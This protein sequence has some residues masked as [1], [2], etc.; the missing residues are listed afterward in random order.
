MGAS[1]SCEVVIVGA[2]MA[3]MTAALRLKDRDILV[4]ESEPE[5]GGRTLS[6]EWYSHWANVGAATIAYDDRVR[7]TALA[8][9]LG[10]N[11]LPFPTMKPPGWPMTGLSPRAAVE[12]AEVEERFRQEAANPRDP[13][14]PE[15]DDQT[16]AE[17][18]GECGGE[19]QQRYE[20]WFGAMMAGSIIDVSLLGGLYLRGDL[21]T[22]PWSTEEVPRT[23]RGPLT[24]QGGMQDLA[25][26]AAGTV[27]H[28]RVKTGSQVLNIR[29]ATRGPAMVSYRENG[30]RKSVNA[31]CVIVTTPAP[32]VRA[33][34]PS[35]PSARLR[36]L[37]AVTYGLVMTTPVF[38]MPKGRAPEEPPKLSYARPGLRYFTPALGAHGLKVR[39]DAF[40]IKNVFYDARAKAVWDDPDH[41]IA[42]G[43]IRDLYDANPEL[44]G[45]AHHVEVK[46]FQYGIARYYPGRMKLLSLL[47]EPFRRVHFAGDYTDLSNIEGAVRSGERAAAEARLEL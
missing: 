22:T 14:L 26:R 37:G 6:R 39:E 29:P 30:E 38:L 35:L 36:A 12:V 34:M 33:I 7:H 41:T 20:A 18:I 42:T 43:V 3:G 28:S 10:C 45:R 11:L 46:R 44:V 27:G 9:E 8:E 5:V 16:L 47:R 21:S 24:I 25:L 4:L 31:R 1:E 2:G 19:A 32:I 17:F 13:T 23:G 40:C 15:L